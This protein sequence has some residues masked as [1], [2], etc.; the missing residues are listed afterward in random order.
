M[1]LHTA[2]VPRSDIEIHSEKRDALASH[3]FSFKLVSTSLV[4]RGCQWNWMHIISR[5]LV[6]ANKKSK[7]WDHVIFYLGLILKKYK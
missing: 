2:G 3:A 4:R 6:A 7:I 1:A 5:L